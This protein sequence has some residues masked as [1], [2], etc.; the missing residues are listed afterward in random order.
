LAAQAARSG[1]DDITRIVQMVKAG[2]PA[3]E[4]GLLTGFATQ[5][6]PPGGV[7]CGSLSMD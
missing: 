4:N 5:A 6:R 3:L 2:T 7:L 1:R